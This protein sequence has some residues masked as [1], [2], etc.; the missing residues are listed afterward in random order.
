MKTKTS[1]QELRKRIAKMESE[2]KDLH[3]LYREIGKKAQDG[4]KRIHQ[5]DDN[6]KLS[7]I[8]KKMGL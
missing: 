4:V 7:A 8:R 1:A 5:D 6:D 3:K 2:I